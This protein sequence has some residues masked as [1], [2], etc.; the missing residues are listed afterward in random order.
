MKDNM[1]KDSF[2]SKSCDFTIFANLFAE[3]KKKVTVIFEN[4]VLIS[5]CQIKLS[6][7]YMPKKMRH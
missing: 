4:N 2:Q 5:I 6:L 7:T 3:T 1:R